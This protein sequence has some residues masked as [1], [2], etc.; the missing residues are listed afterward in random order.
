[1]TGNLRHGLLVLSAAFL[2]LAGCPRYPPIF[3]DVLGPGNGERIIYDLRTSLYAHLQN[4]PS[5]STHAHPIGRLVTRITSDVENLS[6]MFSSA[7]LRSWRILLLSAGRLGMFLT[8]YKL[9]L[10]T[11][12]M[13]PALMLTMGS[14]SAAFA[15]SLR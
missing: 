11:I 14:S 3:P 7:A 13:L 10:I 6:E 15:A 5:A 1:M 12:L 2:G 9:A 8:D 4:C